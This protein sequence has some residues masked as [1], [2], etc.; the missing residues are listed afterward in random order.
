MGRKKPTKNGDDLGSLLHRLENLKQ[1]C[2]PDKKEKVAE[3]DLDEFSRLRKQAARQI[4]E[5]RK[6][7]NE[8]DELLEASSGSGGAQ[9]VTLSHKIRQT[10]K[11]AHESHKA[12]QNF[13]AQEEKDRERQKAKGAK[14][15]LP[16]LAPE[17]VD[18]H[19]GV[20]ELTLKHITECEQLEKK[21]YQSRGV[22]AKGGAK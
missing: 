4:A 5:I 9:S 8:R 19:L 21:R 13:V 10:I 12:M 1:E 3:E 2:A 20:V 6:L 17:E 16:L 7:I 11:E 14:G 22:G 18:E 15:N